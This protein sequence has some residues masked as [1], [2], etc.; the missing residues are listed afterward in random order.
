MKLKYKHLNK[1]CTS[2][3]FKSNRLAN[4]VYHEIITI[5]METFVLAQLSF[6]AGVR[7]LQLR[8]LWL[9]LSAL[10]ALEYNGSTMLVLCQDKGADQAHKLELL[11]P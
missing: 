8:G 2:Y 9:L 6:P 3:L 7:V 10:A 1:D 11:P 4:Q 5:F